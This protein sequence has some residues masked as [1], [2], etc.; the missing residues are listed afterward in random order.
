MRAHGV[1]GGAGLEFATAMVRVPTCSAQDPLER[2]PELRTEHG[3][4]H[5]IQRRIKVAQPQ[6]ERDQGVADYAVSTQR[7]CQCHD[8]K[9]QPAD[10]KGARND[11]QCFGSLSLAFRFQR[12]LASGNLSVGIRRAMLIVIRWIGRGGHCKSGRLLGTRRHVAD[13][14]QLHL[15]DKIADLMWRRLGHADG[16]HGGVGGRV[17]RFAVHCRCLV[18]RLVLTDH[19]R[20]HGGD[21]RHGRCWI[22]CFGKWRERETCRCVNVGQSR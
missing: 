11:G 16:R 17:V 5:W 4:N 10:D 9:W 7:H 15:V 8:E 12:F 22:L 18:V 13:H 21:L 20:R 2:L 1:V 14:R 3:V 19:V 6:E